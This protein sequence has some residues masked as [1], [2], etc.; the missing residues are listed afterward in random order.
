MIRKL[1]K[2]WF[3]LLDRLNLWIL[4]RLAAHCQREKLRRFR[5]L[6][7]SSRNFLN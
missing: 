5:R 2:L 3:A 4:D 7:S 6:L 1:D